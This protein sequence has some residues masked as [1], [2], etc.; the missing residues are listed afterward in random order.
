[1][2]GF[3]TFKEK[4]LHMIRYNSQYQ[5]QIKE[6]SNL[7][8][9][10]LN[11]QNRWIQLGHLLPWDQMVVRYKD[12]FSSQQGAPCVDP[13]QMIGAFIIKHKM[14]LSDEETLQTISENPYMQFF[15]GLDVFCPEPL[16]AESLFSEVRKRLGKDTF[17]AFNELIIRASHPQLK[18]RQEASE[19]EQPTDNKGK[20]KIDATVADQYIRY[21]NDL[22]LVNEARLKTEGIIDQLWERVNDQLP[23]KPRTY[24]QVA[25]KRYL[26]EAKKKRKSAA[27]VRKTLRYLL[28]CVRRNLGHI[29]RMLNVIGGQDF[30]LAYKYQRQLWIIHTLYEQQRGMYDRRTHRCP[31]RIVSLAQPHVRPIV[32]GKQ[33]TPVEFGSKLG[34]SLIDGYLTTHTLSWDAYNESSDLQGQAEAYKLLFGYY[35]ALIQADKIY[36]TN[37]NRSWCKQRNIRL[38]AVP[39]GRP[40]KKTAC[41]K[42]RERDE[43]AE[44]N[45]IEGRIGNGK[46]AFSLNQIKAKLRQTSEAWIALTIFVMNLSV[47]ATNLNATF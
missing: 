21:P 22:S 25:H 4:T 14:N 47:F 44:R 8:S 7:Y 34:L 12:Y 30:P 6:F 23:V 19:D 31:D 27:S 46:Q 26:G 42:R 20:L 3:R 17:E 9:L 41:Q 1:M 38:T 39:K 13:R 11:P 40:P 15:L 43:Y 28:N 32:R 35:P 18:D 10:K 2:Q 33:G 29:D 16:F 37:A 36:W 5:T 45:H 24:R